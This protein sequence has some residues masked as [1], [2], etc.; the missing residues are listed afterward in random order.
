[1]AGLKTP[2][3]GTDSEGKMKSGGGILEGFLEEAGLELGLE[4]G[5]EVSGLRI[6]AQSEGS[7]E[8]C[9]PELAGAGQ[10]GGV[11]VPSPA[12]HLMHTILSLPLPL[13][14]IR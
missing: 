7:E 10:G 6:M 9:R 4:G 2:K 5:V 11:G 3:R 14:K 12:Q 1:M 8:L 13:S